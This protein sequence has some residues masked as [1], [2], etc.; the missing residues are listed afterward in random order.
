M[1]LMRQ[2]AGAGVAAV[3]PLAHDREA[4]QFKLEPVAAW[5]AQE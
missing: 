5:Q 3:V 4:F 2:I 1:F